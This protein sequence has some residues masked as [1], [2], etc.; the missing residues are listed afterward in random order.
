MRGPYSPRELVVGGLPGGPRGCGLTPVVEAGPGD[1][2]DGAQPLDASRI[3]E[4]GAERA[5]GRRPSADRIQLRSVSVFTLRSVATD[6]I[7]A[8]GLERYNATATAVNSAG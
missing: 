8:P 7:V 5:P 4:R 1:P 3:L 2:D 6:L